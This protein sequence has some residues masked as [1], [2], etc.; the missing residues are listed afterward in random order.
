M[1]R[2]TAVKV[3]AGSISSLAL[4]LLLGNAL[5]A[6]V[7]EALSDVMGTPTP[8][9]SDSES[10]KAIDWDWWLSINGDIV[11]W[12]RV[13]GTTIDFPIV[14]AQTDDPRFY[15]THGV[16]GG[17]NPSGTPYLD[18][19]CLAAGL[20]SDVCFIFGHNMSDGSMFSPFASY[21]E[22]GYAAGHS[23]VSILTPDS[24]ESYAVDAVRLV[25]SDGKV[26]RTAFS[27]R[28]A[29]AKW[30]SEQLRASEHIVNAYEPDDGMSSNF[31]VFSTCTNDGSGRVVVYTHRTSG[32][33][34]Q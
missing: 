9:H 23:T 10:G 8:P 16:D 7:T 14:Q 29:A 27:N 24:S 18:S 20:D 19:G 4:G 28:T 30:Y 12:V 17:R 25:D 34:A 3:V 5:R 33:D 32:P 15:L 22:N 2:R 21:L 13:D 1:D 31:L 26:K 11:G 6:P